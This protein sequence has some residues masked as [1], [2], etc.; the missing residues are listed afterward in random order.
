[1]QNCQELIPPESIAKLNKDLKQAA[2]VLT[3]Q[4]VR[5]LVDTYYSIQEY[6]KRTDNQIRAMLDAAEPHQ[7]S[8]W[9]AENIRCF[10]NQIKRALDA[11]SDADPIGVRIRTVHG[12]GPVIAAGFLAHID[13]TKAPTAGAIWRFA[14]LD[15]TMEWGK[16]QKR[17]YNASLKTLCWKLGQSFLKTYTNQKSFYGP[18]FQ[19]R[20]EHEQQQNEQLAYKNQAEAKLKRFNIGKTT[21]AYKAYSKGKLPPAHILQRAL[22]WTVKLFL[23]HLFEAMYRE[24]Y[25][26][27]PPECYVFEHLGHVHKV[28]CPF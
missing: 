28:E 1:M 4:E 27:E 10:E 24:H 8:V 16:G 23:S 3:D 14:G 9:L 7:L 13:I 6:R 17:P 22:R 20:W 21:D 19:K 11:Y 26:K 5:Y 18:Y 12:V 15:P 25:D 2:T